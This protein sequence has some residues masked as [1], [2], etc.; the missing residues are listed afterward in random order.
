MVLDLPGQSARMN[1]I[2]IDVHMVLICSSV[3]LRY[4]HF[5]L[6]DLYLPLDKMTVLALVSDQEMADQSPA[7]ASSPA[8]CL[9]L[10]DQTKSVTSLWL[11]TE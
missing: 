6:Q 4:M 9:Q 2:Q 11:Q 7:S 8:V 3:S 1:F 5:P 10:T